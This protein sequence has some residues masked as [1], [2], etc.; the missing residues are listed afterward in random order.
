MTSL[1][2][3]LHNCKACHWSVFFYLDKSHN[4]CVLNDL[5]LLE[6]EGH[7]TQFNLHAVLTYIVIIRCYFLNYS[8]PLFV[9]Q[10]VVKQNVLC[11][12]LDRAKKNLIV[13]KKG[14]PGCLFSRKTH[15]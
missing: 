11:G 2:V 15:P 1:R 4:K 5:E 6:K 7:M 13:Y 8:G 9:P 12:A 10:C 14:V 3:H